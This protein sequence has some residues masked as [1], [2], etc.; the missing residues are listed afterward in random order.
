MGVLIGHLE[1]EG[2]IKNVIIEDAVPI[3]HGGSIE[4][5][6][7]P[8]D[9]V[10]FSYVDADYA[11]QGFFSCGWYHSHPALKI[12]FSSTDIKNQLGWQTPNPSAIGI[13]FD[14]TYLA[15]PGDVGFRTFRLDDPSKGPMTDYHEV[16]T[17]VEPPDSVEYY[18]KIMEIINSIHS[19]EPPILELNETPDLFGDILVPGQSQIMAKQ[20]ELELTDFLTALQTGVSKLIEL[21]IEPLIR[22]FNTWSQDL[23]KNVVENNLQIRT[24]LV[25]LKDSISSGINK[26]QTSVKSLITNKLWDL[27]SYIDDKLETFD[28]D[29]EVIKSTIDHLRED[30]NIQIKELFADKINATVEPI[31]TLF[32]Q[33]SEIITENQEESVKNIENLEAQQTSLDSLSKTISSIEN[34]TKDKLNKAQEKISSN[35]ADK[36]SKITDSFTEVSKNANEFKSDLDTAISLLES[37]KEDLQNKMKK[38]EEEMKKP[39][40][41]M[42]KPEEEMKKPEGGDP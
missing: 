17:I 38:P 16:K 8:E 31:F 12:F 3:S 14:H 9:Y 41:E 20:P 35:I 42:K 22:F 40:E 19:K 10:S 32:K 27:D 2:D 23:V 28:K 30:L 13:V 18:I 21:S 24:D 26:I 36:V 15:T 11:E 29:R 25:A 34:S 4:V 33:L 7:K 37:I 5:A 6:F 1:G 39:E